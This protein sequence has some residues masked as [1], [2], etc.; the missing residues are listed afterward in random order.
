MRSAPL[1]A[2]LRS[3]HAKYLYLQYVKSIE[4]SEKQQ[5]TIQ[6]YQP[7][8]LCPPTTECMLTHSPVCW[9]LTLMLLRLTSVRPLSL[10]WIL[11]TVSSTL[12]VFGGSSGKILKGSAFTTPKHIKKTFPETNQQV[13]LRTN[14][15]INIRKQV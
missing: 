12:V 14:K 3:L 11:S 2:L 9:R 8:E 6:S 7:T 1:T 15:A 5:S 4:Y 10:L 13:R